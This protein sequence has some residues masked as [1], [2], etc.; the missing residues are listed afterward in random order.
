MLKELF[1]L[2]QLAQCVPRLRSARALLQLRL[3]NK[4]AATKR[5]SPP[6]SPNILHLHEYYLGAARDK[7]YIV[8]ELLRGGELLDALL[9][10]GSYSERDART[11]FK[12]VRQ[13]PRIAD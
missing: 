7:V 9:E 2:K 10:R 12:S 1:I 6:R 8:T 13:Q 5:R 4:H 3:C 11:I